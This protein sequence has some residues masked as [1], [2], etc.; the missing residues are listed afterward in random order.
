MVINYR[1]SKKMH[2]SVVVIIDCIIKVIV[3]NLFNYL[4]T[5]DANADREMSESFVKILF[6]MNSNLWDKGKHLFTI[7]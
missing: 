4:S 3:I 1:C 5:F 2:T 7:Y 6:P